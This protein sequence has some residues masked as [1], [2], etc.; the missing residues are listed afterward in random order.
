MSAAVDQR[1]AA[2]D[3]VR[4]RIRRLEGTG[5][6]T[7]SDPEP[8]VWER[9]EGCRVWD[10]DGRSYLDLYAGFAVATVGYCHP[11][12]TEAI[13]RQAGTMTHCPPAAPS[14]VRADLYE[15]L[16]GIAPSGLERVLL[17][18]TGAMANE[19]AV[20][21][22]RAATGRVNVISFSGAYLGRSVGS[23]RYAGK[24]GYRAQLGVRGDAQFAPY[25]DPYRSPWASSPDAGAA[26]LALDNYF[27]DN[28]VRKVFQSLPCVRRG[29][30][31]LGFTRPADRAEES[32]LPAVRMAS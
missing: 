28:R 15:R 11:R 13:R 3:E 18:V 22:A 16:I 29:L 20:Q 17:S 24:H 27:M 12:V 26:V 14:A 1:R 8:L 10:R 23:V 21:L 9:T 19:T 31:R 4:D 2:S 6:R 5:M 32:K 7:F 25:P 30:E